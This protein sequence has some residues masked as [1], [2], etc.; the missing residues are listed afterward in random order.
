MSIKVEV[1]DTGWL[2]FFKRAREIRDKRVRVGVL[3]DDAHGDG[4]LTLS[5]LATIHEFGTEDKRI[6]ERSFLR[7]TFD[8]KREELA[9]V[10]EK[11]IGA[12]L[13]GKMTTERGL[14][15]IGAKLAADVKG[16]ITAGIDPPNAPTTVA[17]K[18]SSTPLV[19]TGRLLNSITWAVDEGEGEE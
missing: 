3:S 6:P 8:E 13:D 17:R 16:R 4:D 1:K 14:G 12:V 9:E 19:D 2:E 10:G 7:S 15:L 11:L 18:G 5:E